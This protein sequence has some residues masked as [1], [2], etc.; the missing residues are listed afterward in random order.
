M[1]NNVTLYGYTSNS[2]APNSVQWP[3]VTS[4][5]TR[6]QSI[7]R[8]A[9]GSPTAITD[10]AYPGALPVQVAYNGANLPTNVTDC[11]GR[12]HGVYYNSSNQVAKLRQ[13]HNGAAVDVG[14]GYNNNLLCA[15][16]NQLSKTWQI[17]R[18]AAG[19]VTSVVDP[20]SVTNSVEYDALGR[21]WKVHDPRMSSPITY[22]YDNL[23]RV[24]SVYTPFST[25]SYIYD[26]TKQW[27][28]SVT[29]PLNRTTYYSYNTT[30][31]KITNTTIA[32]PLS[33][34]SVTN[35][36]TTYSYT[37]NGQLSRVT[38]PGAKPISYSYNDTGQ[39]TSTFETDNGMSTV[40]RI[41][42]TT[43]R[44]TAIGPT[45]RITAS[46]GALPLVRL[47]SLATIM[48]KTARRPPTAPLC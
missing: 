18:D 25:N 46:R 45:R 13:Y 37:T 31:G 6:N 17:N 2:L 19:R 44:K 43:M 21:L 4:V 36:T 47:Q 42:P 12:N 22:N 28:A 33:G 26:P 5:G 1:L 29:D 41:S 23:N 8:N 10:S 40:R 35:L 20:T 16:T 15:I 38:P 24:T 9:Y 7:Q 14:F 48:P 3:L 11:S 39:M 30:N 27:L 34:S 32:I